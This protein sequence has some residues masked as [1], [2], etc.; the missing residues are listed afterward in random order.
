MPRRLLALLAIALAAGAGAAVAG[1]ASPDEPT[2]ARVPSLPRAERRGQACPLPSRYRRAFEAAARETNL[3]LALLVAVGQVE[4]N[5]RANARS[6]AGAKGLLQV[7]P[8]TAA[9]LEL[10]AD[11]PRSNV[12]A[13]ARYLRQLLRRFDSTDLALA[14]YN[15]GPT[16]VE[17]FGGAPS[18]ATLTYVADVTALW[19]ELH[20]CR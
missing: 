4:S 18:Q 1:T 15:A 7:M 12:L 2:A 13:G 14:A 16:S 6:Q 20:G 11:E 19:R 9:S 3:P 17:A 5:L 8:E 10:D